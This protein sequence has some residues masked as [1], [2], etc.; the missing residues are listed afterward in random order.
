MLD[1]AIKNPASLF[2]HYLTR[3]NGTLFFSVDDGESGIKLWKSDGT[4][5][6]T[7]PMKTLT[8]LTICAKIGRGL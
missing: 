6:G 1:R 4:E 5:A 2:H 3:I 7:T 8:D